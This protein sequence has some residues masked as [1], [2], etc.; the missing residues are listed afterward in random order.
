MIMSP[1]IDAAISIE[2]IKKAFTSKY[3]PDLFAGEMTHHAA[4]GL[5]AQLVPFTDDEDLLLEIVRSGLPENYEGDTLEEI[6]AMVKGAIAKGFG[7]N[8][9][10]RLADA[11]KSLASQVVKLAMAK[12]TELFHDRN[13]RSY[14]SMLTEKGGSRTL[15]LNS[16]AALDWLGGL[17]YATARGA[18]PSKSKADALATLHANALYAGVQHSISIRIARTSDAMYVDLGGPDYAVVKIHGGGWEVTQAHPIKFIRPSSFAE[19]PAPSGGGDLAALQGLLQLSDAAWPLVLAFII[20]AVRPTGPYFCLLVDGE[21]GSGKSLLCSV[22]KRIVDPSLIDKLPL[23]SSDDQLFIQAKDSHLLVFDNAS[24]MR[25]DISDALCR[26]A[27]G[28][29]VAKRM[30]YTN[31]DLHII[32]QCNPFV[33]NGIGDFVHRPDLLERSI[34]LSLSAMPE[35]SRRTEQQILSNLEG[36]LPGFLG[37]L[38]DIASTAFRDEETTEAPRDI[39]MADA[40]RWLKAA[41]PATGL[42]KGTLLE[43]IEESQ[44]ISLVDRIRENSLFR[45]IDQLL[46]ENATFKGGVGAL[47]DL[48]MLRNERPDRAFPKT[49]SH[50]S[51]QLQ[52][53]RPAMAKAGIAVELKHRGREGRTVSIE[54]TGPQKPAGKKPPYPPY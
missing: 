28:G 2:F 34:L 31:D 24:G 45:A 50:L 13:K 37:R 8:D 15:S 14:I 42:R 29:A 19:L 26:L 39:R 54:R 5:V 16:S 47:H 48:L 27:T 44:T 33:I 9:T 7:E 11:T 18:L 20:S 40:A 25:N 3:Y 51:T 12:A 53:L 46:E 49:A 41:E 23:P 17:W 4:L 36:V 1:T 21:Q 35:G 38:F 22:L 43:A 32:V 6:S 30:L 52:R 10:T